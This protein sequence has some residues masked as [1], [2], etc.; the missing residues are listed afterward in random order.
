[1]YIRYI[2]FLLSSGLKFWTKKYYKYYIKNRCAFARA[3]R[4]VGWI[5]SCHQNGIFTYFLQNLKIWQYCQKTWKSYILKLL[6]FLESLIHSNFFNNDYMNIL[7]RG[8]DSPDYVAIHIH[9]YL[10]KSSEYWWQN[11]LLKIQ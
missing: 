11:I 2:I 3:P 4:T 1:M 8:N 7:T 5:Y 9:P 6:I 10:L